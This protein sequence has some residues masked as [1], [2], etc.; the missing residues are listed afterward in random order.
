M[1][2]N[3]GRWPKI[4]QDGGIGEAPV[5]RWRR[6]SPDMRPDGRTEPS[7]LDNLTPGEQ[8]ARPF[9]A[10]ADVLETLAGLAWLGQAGR[11]LV[12]VS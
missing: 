5:I 3:R 12:Q 8:S 2:G 9:T 4:D 10:T 6:P 7:W 11:P 1:T